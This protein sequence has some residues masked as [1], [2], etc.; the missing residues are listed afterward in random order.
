MQADIPDEHEWMRDPEHRAEG[1]VCRFCGITEA[2]AET[3]T[4][5]L[6]ICPIAGR[7]R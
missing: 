7:F 2:E 5:A 4:D 3:V 1:L 6:V